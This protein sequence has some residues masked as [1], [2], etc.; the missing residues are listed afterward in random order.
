MR[1]IPKKRETKRKKKIGGKENETVK[2]RVVYT[3]NS[4]TKG[5]LTVKTYCQIKIKLV[6][7]CIK[8]NNKISNSIANLEKESEII[9][10]WSNDSGVDFIKVG[11]TA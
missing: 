4:Q 5:G 1:R 7:R 9:V 3:Q 6:E 2:S 11:R 10:L 8:W